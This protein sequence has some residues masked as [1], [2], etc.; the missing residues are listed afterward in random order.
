MQ[1]AR[2]LYVYLLTGVGLGVLVAG[3]SMLLTVLFEQVGLGRSGAALFGGDETTRLQLTLA[4]ALT[5]VSLPVW[6]IHWFVAE[7]SIRPGRS[8]ADA[9]RN[10][11]IRGLYFALALGALVAVTATSLGGLLATTIEALAGSDVSYRNPA[12]DVALAVVAGAAWAYHVAVRNRD[13]ARGQIAGAAA[14][15]PRTYLYVATFIGLLVMLVGINGLIELIGRLV[16]DEPPVFTGDESGPW[17]AFPLATAMSQ[18]VVGGALWLG[19]TI[20]AARQRAD[21]RWRGASERP[22]RLRVAYFAAVI[23]AGAIAVAFYLAEGGHN[24]FAAILGVSDARG[25]SEQVGLILLPI[26]SAVPFGISW[27]MHERQLRNEAATF[28]STDRMRT[29]DRLALHIAAVVGLVYAAVGSAWLL[30]LMIDLA[31]GGGRAIAEGDVWQRQLAQFVPIA[32]AGSTL[33]LFKWAAI[34]ARAA[35]NPVDEAGATTRRTALLLVLAGSVLAVIGSLGTILYRLFGSI[36]GIEETGNV[37]ADLST[38]IGILI[39]GAGVA[40]YHGLVLR[41][42]Q[43]LRAGAAPAAAA[44]VAPLVP[45]LTLRLLGPVGGDAEAALM[46]IRERLPAGFDLEVVTATHPI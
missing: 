27:L 31:V 33:W 12:A 4:S 9:E 21:A 35:Q 7:R 10:S 3:L 42:D 5:T 30:G 34:R 44:E 46:A 28:D 13:W 29:A 41:R 39:V 2:R 16:L 22:A 14:S 24:A 15:L 25:T 11:A 18:V 23:G 1:T 40:A 19:H 26:L 8:T 32:L 38:P 36:F 17:W 20:H 6:L 45:A 37:L 43:A